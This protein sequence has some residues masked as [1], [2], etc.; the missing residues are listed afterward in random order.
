MLVE[1]VSET[2]A[3]AN[4]RKTIIAR[5]RALCPDSLLEPI[6]EA[7]I[8][9]RF[10]RTRNSWVDVDPPL[11]LVRMVLVRERRWAIPRVGGIHP[12]PACRRFAAC[13]P[14]LRFAS[15]RAQHDSS[16]S[17]CKPWRFTLPVE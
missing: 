14:G 15:I 12:H 17:S 2:M 1:P 13:D 16:P 7:A 4:G 3:A 9:Q 5:L 8:F 11:Q 6:A 10:N